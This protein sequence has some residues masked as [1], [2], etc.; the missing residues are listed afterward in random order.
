MNKIIFG[1]ICML[2]SI[3]GI[4]TIISGIFTLGFKTAILGMPVLLEQFKLTYLY[5][6]FYWLGVIGFGLGILGIFKK[7]KSGDLKDNEKT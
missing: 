2:I 7:N 5:N 6:I 1:G 3:I 4:T